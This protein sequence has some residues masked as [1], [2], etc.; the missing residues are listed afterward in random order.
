MFSY[1]KW[2]I[3]VDPERLLTK[4]AKNFTHAV[5]WYSW[6]IVCHSQHSFSSILLV[7]RSS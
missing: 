2:T 6:A 5:W 7:I 1:V 4:L 3:L